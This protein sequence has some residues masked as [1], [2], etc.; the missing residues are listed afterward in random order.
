MSAVVKGLH[1]FAELEEFSVEEEDEDDIGVSLNGTA[2]LTAA[3]QRRCVSSI[4]IKEGGGTSACRGVCMMSFSLCWFL[5]GVGKRGGKFVIGAQSAYLIPVEVKPAKNASNVDRWGD[6]HF[7]VGWEGGGGGG[8]GV[9]GPTPN[10]L[11]YKI[12]YQKLIIKLLV[13]SKA[14]AGEKHPQSGSQ[15]ACGSKNDPE[16]TPEYKKMGKNSEKTAFFT[17]WPLWAK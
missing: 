13:I 10:R 12:S 9:G 16:A 5:S 4:G 14:T 8:G 11:V 6:V 1:S 7:S 17:F 15:G 2:M 3:L